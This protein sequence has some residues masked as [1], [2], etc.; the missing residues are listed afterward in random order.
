L[1]ILLCRVRRNLPGSG[2]S[3]IPL[4]WSSATL[5]SHPWSRVSC[6]SQRHF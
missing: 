2:R 4:V 6:T 3:C 1:F 5:A